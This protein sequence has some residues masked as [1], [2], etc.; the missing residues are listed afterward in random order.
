MIFNEARFTDKGMEFQGVTR[1]VGTLKEES[2][3]RARYLYEKNP[4]ITLGFSSGLDSQITFL[5]FYEQNLPIKCIF[6]HYPGYNDEEHN[7][8]QQFRERYPMDLRI[9]EIDPY[10]LKDH[11]ISEGEKHKIHPN[12][13]LHQHMVK[14]ID[15]ESLYVQGPDVP[16]FLPIDDECYYW[17]SPQWHE[18]GKKRAFSMLNRP[19][20]EIMWDKNSE[21]TLS[22]AKDPLYQAFMYARDYFRNNGILL[23]GK[24]PSLLDYWDIYVKPVLFHQHY[25]NQLIYF[26]KIQGPENIDF[27]MKVK[28][29]DVL[30]KYIKVKV[31][32]L[33]Q[34][35]ETPGTH[36][37]PF[38]E[39]TE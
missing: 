36:L 27:I 31:S 25:Q 33:I 34:N 6:M 1:T 38:K 21:M 32:E 2:L 35:L 26:P 5:S 39:S 8:V 29:P 10:S 13:I 20:K 24:K 11:L 9:V 4:N 30:K 12:Q 22:F 28:T 15:P 14:M 7:N 3:L 37:F 23:H 19:G 16:F 17:E 18:W